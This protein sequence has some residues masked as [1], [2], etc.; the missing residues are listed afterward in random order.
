M[1]VVSVKPLRKRRVPPLGASVARVLVVIT[2]AASG[3]AGAQAPA[4]PTKPI[5]YIVP[6][7]PAGT[8]DVCARF[9][10]QKMQERMGQPVVIENRAGAN[11]AIGIE[12]AAKAAGDG[13]T[14]LQGALSG[15]VMNTIF[16]E[17]AGNKLPYDVR[18]DLTAVSMV[19]TS[20]L[21]L[22]VHASVGARNIKELIAVARAKPGKLTYS[23]NGVGGT[24]H[25][26]VALF[27]HRMGLNMVHVPYKSGAQST[28]DVVTGV[29]DMLFGGS[30]LLPHAKA[31]KVHI[32][33]VG[34]MQRAGA[35]PDVPTMHEQGVTGF[36]VISW[37]ALMAPSSTPKPIIDRLYRE[38][39]AIL[40][41]GGARDGIAN[42]D[43]ELISSTPADLN[44]RIR[45]DFQVWEKTIRETGIKIE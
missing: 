24:Q 45:R 4:Y 33:A 29:I 21:Y 3:G 13:Y 28:T 39:E 5:R 7:A 30:L 26:A 44:E 37:F 42:N 11:Q 31:G 8:G 20:P 22:G 40:R 9:H 41:P 10:A 1:N 6:F 35:T 38:T 25:L 17:I 18:R 2:L 16:A 43:V 27:A 14:V 19:C 15:I 36:D 23:S 32:V 34:H 12:A